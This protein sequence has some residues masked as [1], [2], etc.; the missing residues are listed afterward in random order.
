MP[1]A[2]DRNVAAVRRFNRFY[3]QRLGF[4]RDGG[5]Y[6]PFSLTQAR[7]L[8]ELAQRPTCTASQIAAELALDHGYLSRILRGFQSDGIHYP[9][10][11]GP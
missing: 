7:V 9:H 2:I 1:A 10:A 4:L 5:L 6:A 3:T 11:R 8:Y